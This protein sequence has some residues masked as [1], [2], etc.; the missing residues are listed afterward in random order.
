M[1]TAYVL[2]WTPEQGED[3][4]SVLVDEDAVAHVELDR[5]NADAAPILEVVPIRKYVVGL[6]G[7]DRIR[8][9]V[10]LD[11]VRRGRVRDPNA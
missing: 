2:Y 3:L 5:T 9:A 11:L 1:S 7:T 8:L 10:A 4:Y 6:G